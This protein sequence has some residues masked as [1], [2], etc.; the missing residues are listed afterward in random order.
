MDRFEA[1]VLNYG[2]GEQTVAICVMIAE[3]VLP[4]PHRIVMA[5]TSREVSSTWNYLTEHVRPYLERHSLPA[6]E[7]A[8]HDLATVDIY[9]HKGTLLLPVFHTT[10]KMSAWCSG[11]WKTEVVH[12]HLRSS[13]VT[14]ATQWIGYAYDEPRR[15]KGKCLEDAPWRIAFPLVDRMIVKADCPVI[16]KKAGLP[17]VR[18]SRCFMCPNQPNAEWRELRDHSPEEFE[19]AC[20]IDEEVRED[21]E[22][23]S[24]F[25]HESKVPLRVADLEAADRKEP[26]RQCT[27]GICFV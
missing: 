17:P 12:R 23:G 9:S 26:N 7:V 15:W 2:G 14:S 20:R 18:K 25:L 8:S 5:D 21:D 4:R 24:V 6:V 13:G 16:I 10:G 19:A 22:F 3:G 1:L 27:L 11:E